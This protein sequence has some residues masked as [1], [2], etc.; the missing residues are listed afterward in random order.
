MR[1]KSKTP[2]DIKDLPI[3]HILIIIT[4]TIFAIFSTLIF[5]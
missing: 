1:L 2:G 5:I 3:T 4:L